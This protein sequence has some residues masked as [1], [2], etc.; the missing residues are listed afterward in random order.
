MAQ[1]LTVA[2]F[3]EAEKGKFHIPIQCDRLEDLYNHFGN[4]P[5]D[6][7]GLHA[8]IEGIL[9][10]REIFYLRVHEEGFSE[11]DYF[12]GLEHL[13]EL[14]KKKKIDALFLPGVG[15]EKIINTA[16][17]LIASY[18]AILLTTEKDLYDYITSFQ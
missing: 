3:G 12:K 14:M 1:L 7:Q 8:A 6:S 15:D 5:E 13:K 17:L 10:G 2:L 11:K 4:P 9:L 18:Q 16:S